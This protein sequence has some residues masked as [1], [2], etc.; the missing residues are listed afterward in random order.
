MN[1]R[2]PRQKMPEQKPEVRRTN[3]NEVSL[4]FT[5]EMAKIEASRCLQCKKPQCVEGCPVNVNIP[6]FIA[7]VVEGKFVEAIKVIKGSNS[8]PA[9]CGR[10]CPQESQCE[11]RCILGKKFEPVAIGKLEGFVADYER[12][13]EH[14]PAHIPAAKKNKKIAVIGSGPAGLTVAGECAKAGYS[15]TVYE[16]LHTPGGVLVYG[17]PEFRLPK[18]IVSYEINALAA[19][20]VEFVNNRVVGLSET[21][22]DI[23]SRFDAAFVATG[24]GL[25]SFLN[26]PGENLQGVYSA[27]EYLTRV[28]LMKAY[29]FPEY[30]T[31]V[32]RGKSMA[33]FGGGNV[34]MDSA[35]TAVRLGCNDV[36]LVYRRSKEEMPARAEEVHHA[37][38]EGVI[39]DLLANP[40]RLIGDENGRLCGVECIRMELGEPDESGRRKPVEKK[41][42]EFIIKIDAAIIAVGNGSNPILQ[43]T[44]PDLKCNK[45]GNII[46]DEE[47]MKTSVKGVFAG[48]DIVTGAATVIQAMGAGR[49]AA[50]G[51]MEFLES[52]NW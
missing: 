3:F 20:G 41:G 7:Q 29:K 39:F 21:L 31:P 25:P 26:I 45:W 13:K 22:A 44:A 17:I 38:E 19:M 9:V 1:E 51:I 36:H 10:V 4:G 48:G 27:N 11:A 5:P 30:D 24:A 47:T 15:V 40:V 32:I 35:R 34:A 50:K 6:G 2:T 49:K 43:K 37:E 33:V 18:K 16:A 12:E 28:N 46:A 23:M 14:L 52:G 8:L 42:S